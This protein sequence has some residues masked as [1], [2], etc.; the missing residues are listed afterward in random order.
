MT[1][2]KA[3]IGAPRDRQYVLAA[4]PTPEV[5]SR[6]GA[7][8]V[9]DLG[10]RRPAIARQLDPVGGGHVDR[11]ASDHDAVG[12]DVL[13]LGAEL[14]E[15]PV[16]PGLAAV[17]RQAP[18]V[19]HRAVP[20]LAVGSE[21]ERLHVVEGDRPRR[22]V[23]RVLQLLPAAGSPLEHE[24]PLPIRAHPDR[25]VGRAGDGEHVGIRGLGEIRPGS[26]RRRPPA[27]SARLVQ[28]IGDR[29]RAGALTIGPAPAM[30]SR[31]SPTVRLLA[32]LAI[33]LSANT[34]S[35][36]TESPSRRRA[37]PA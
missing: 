33:T 12:R 23:G 21:T 37:T 30:D 27:G 35:A 3:A 16:R 5:G 24:H 11:V 19:P 18:A 9:G 4:D 29:A 36:T 28:P 34:P 10:P 2:P 32:G 20:D 22:R 17:G 1:H 15:L 8:R 26:R 25:V 13:P 14:L 7:A 6:G 31:R